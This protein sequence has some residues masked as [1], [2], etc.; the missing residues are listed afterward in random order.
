LPLASCLCVASGW[1]FERALISFNSFVRPVPAACPGTGVT[2]P[3]WSDSGC[4]TSP[5]RRCRR[6]SHTLYSTDLGSSPPTA[7]L[8]ADYARRNPHHSAP[9][10]VTRAPAG[11][12]ACRAKPLLV[13]WAGLGSGVRQGRAAGWPR[14]PLHTLN[15]SL[16]PL[17]PMMFQTRTNDN[18]EKRAYLGTPSNYKGVSLCVVSQ[19]VGTEEARR[20]RM[21]KHVL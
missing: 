9:T 1:T 8:Y 21:K 20:L 6:V 7:S 12:L 4:S 3:C 15:P 17:L 19:T 11:W 5:S 16:A 13:V 2:S 18:Q 14:K 10:A